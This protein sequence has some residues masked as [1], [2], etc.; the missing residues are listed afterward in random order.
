L[1]AVITGRCARSLDGRVAAEGASCARLRL[2][3]P[4]RAIGAGVRAG[5]IGGRAGAVVAQWAR[6]LGHRG[7]RAE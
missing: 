1:R 4:R 7:R 6:Q 3:R 2:Q 5:Q